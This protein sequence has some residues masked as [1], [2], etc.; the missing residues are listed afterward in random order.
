MR[1]DITEDIMIGWFFNCRYLIIVF[2]LYIYAS[3]SQAC[4]LLVDIPVLVPKLGSVRD[5]ESSV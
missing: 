1:R 2:E 4:K 5:E 3:Q